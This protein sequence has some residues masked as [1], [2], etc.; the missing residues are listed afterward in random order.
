[1]D[2]PKRLF[3]LTCNV[4]LYV[5]ILGFVAGVFTPA[6]AKDE[7][8]RQSGNILVKFKADVSEGKIQEVADHF[9]AH[10]IKPLSDTELSS[11]KNAERWR[12]FRFELVDDLKSI[13][14]RIL[15]DNRVD[16]VE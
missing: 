8:V 11:H 14:W 5:A 15:Q 12:K 2:Q 4:M 1:M 7:P 9:G 6:I 3:K 13:A 10:Q 16:A